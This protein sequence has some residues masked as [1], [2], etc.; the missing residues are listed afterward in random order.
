MIIVK[1]STHFQKNWARKRKTLKVQI[2]RDFIKN[3]WHNIKMPLKRQWIW[4]AYFIII[5]FFAIRKVYD[6]VMPSSSDFLYYF[7]LRSFNS[8]FYITYSAH[9]IHVFLNIIHCIPL[10]LYIYKIRFL[11][12]EIW[13]YLFILRCIF[14]ISGHSYQVNTL[15]ALFDSNPILLLLTILI[16]LLTHFPS[17]IACYWYAFRQEK[18]R[19]EPPINK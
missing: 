7:I 8:V 13:R 5:L 12:P 4:E 11:N 10:F 17:Y 9:V 6:L 2:S 14:E 16:P 3:L 19:W 1:K 18:I 15:T